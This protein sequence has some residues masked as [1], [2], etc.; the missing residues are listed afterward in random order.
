MWI[1]IGFD[2][3]KSRKKKV[4]PQCALISEFEDVLSRKEATL[5]VVLF[6]LYMNDSEI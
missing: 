1:Y 4:P 3:H 6:R 2:L 5:W